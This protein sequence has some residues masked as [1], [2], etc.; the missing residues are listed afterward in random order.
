MS[1]TKSG[2]IFDESNSVVNQILPHKNKWAWDLFMKGCANNWM[3]TEIQMSKD[4]SQ[5]NDPKVLSDDEKMLIKRCLGFFAGSES[6]V[7][8]NLL[9]NIFSFVADAECRQYI[10]RQAFEESLHN[11]TVVYMCDTL[12][13]DVSEVYEAYANIPSIKAKDDFL[14]NIISSSQ[15][16]SHLSRLKTI[17]I[18][19]LICE[20]LFFY[21]GFAML[22]NFGRQNKM[23][24]VS[25]QIQYTM[26]DEALHVQFGTE[27]INTIKYQY[28]QLWTEEF[29]NELVD[30]F[31][32]A[33]DLEINYAKDVLPNGIL[34][35][36]SDMFIDYVKF[37][38]DRRLK[39]IG[40]PSKYSEA[41]NP[42]SWMS[43]SIDLPKMKNFF[44]SKVTDYQTGT[45]ADDF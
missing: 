1:V 24:G 43:E 42:F 10:L 11:L 37:I 35:L 44:E 45:L 22:L 31:D 30:W 9:M 3:P 21:C 15:G 13:V 19:Y 41:K 20:G 7:S 36:K 34:G 4:I 40:L 6:L 26:R 29:K 12:K 23:Y 5:W 25:E 33:I 32:K 14:M 27:L 16:D 18:Y 39:S 2:L 8:N 28:P 38:A 17:I